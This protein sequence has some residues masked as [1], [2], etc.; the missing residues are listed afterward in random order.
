MTEERRSYD[1]DIAAIRTSLKSNNDMTKDIHKAI[2]G[3][4]GNGLLTNVALNRQAIKRAWW[5][6]GSISGL[7][8]AAV[9][10]VIRKVFIE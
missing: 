1:A 5:W 9:G 2:Y 7:V 4:G 3:N 10:C 6:L 8:V